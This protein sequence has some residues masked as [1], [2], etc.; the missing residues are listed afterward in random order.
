MNVQ[1]CRSAHH[2]RLSASVCRLFATFRL[3]KSKTDKQ[4]LTDLPVVSLEKTEQIIHVRPLEYNNPYDHTR[5]HRHTYFEIMF[6][7]TGGGLQLID[8]QQFE[9][10]PNSCHIIFPQQIHL[11]RR[12]GSTGTVVQFVEEVIPSVQVRNQLRQVSFSDKP[13]IFYENSEERMQSLRPLLDLL[14]TAS[15]K[16]TQI[17][18]EIAIKY[19]EALLLQLVEGKQTSTVAQ[20]SEEQKLLF[21]F[22]QL[23]E[24][25]FTH[26]HSVQEYVKLISTTEKKLAAATKKFLGLSPLQVIHNRVLLEAKRALVFEDTSHKEI[27]F[28][29]G[30]D[31]PASFSQFIKNKTGFSPSE[32]G[33]QLVDIHK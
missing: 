15:E 33:T 18:N 6:F 8:F 22:Q 20:V 27:A 24:E 26:N 32:L 14:K 3:V 2:S 1:M 7:D 12:N 29:L 9:A 19:L 23:L 4:K 28:R 16:K 31:S 11:L 5:E 10:Q 17:S 30:F 21:H 25:Q 13:A